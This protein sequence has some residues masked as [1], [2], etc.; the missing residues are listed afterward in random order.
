ML[1]YSILYF[2]FLKKKCKGI[3]DFMQLTACF[4]EMIVVYFLAGSGARFW[5]AVSNITK[6]SQNQKK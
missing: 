4:M 3:S 1:T 2:A 5:I 6:A